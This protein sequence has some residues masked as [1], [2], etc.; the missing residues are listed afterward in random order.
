M[1][2]FKM[3]DDYLELIKVVSEKNGISQDEVVETAVAYFLRM[4][5]MQMEMHDEVEKVSRAFVQDT[6]SAE[7][8][9]R[10][11]GD[12]KGDVDAAIAEARKQGLID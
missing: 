11:I 9:A 10:K 2:E 8:I 1:P 12:D 4:Y 7:E 6:L 5:F 3:K